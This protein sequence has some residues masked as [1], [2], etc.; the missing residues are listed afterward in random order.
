[1][2]EKRT[3]SN[4]PALLLPDIPE[5]TPEGIRARTIDALLREISRDL[6]VDDAD[7]IARKFNLPPLFVRHA[8]FNDNY[9]DDERIEEYI[10]W[11]LRVGARKA[12]A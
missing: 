1:M 2:S 12:V 11:R 10:A 5:D 8:V 4:T 3:P 7:R 6:D 9:S